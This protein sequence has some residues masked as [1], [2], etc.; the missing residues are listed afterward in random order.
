MAARMIEA[1]ADNARGSFSI[2]GR[3]GHWFSTKAEIKATM[4]EILDKKVNVVELAK[5]IL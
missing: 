5:A 3:V 4:Q 2:I 1:W